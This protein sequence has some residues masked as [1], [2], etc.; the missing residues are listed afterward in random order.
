VIERQDQRVAVGHEQLLHARS[1]VLGGFGQVRER[2]VQL[3]Y[4]KALFAVHVAVDTGVPGAA[5]G[6][7]QDVGVGFRRG[8]VDLAFVT[9]AHNMAKARPF[10]Q[11]A[12]ATKA[13]A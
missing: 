4:A 11:Y 7:L 3:P 6:R 10:R 13:K 12:S 1:K 2:L 5:D 9:H 8:T